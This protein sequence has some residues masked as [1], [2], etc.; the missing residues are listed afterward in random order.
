MGRSVATALALGALAGPAPSA[1]AAEHA[2]SNVQLRSQL[3]KMKHENREMRGELAEDAFLRKIDY[4]GTWGFPWAHYRLFFDFARAHDIRVVGVN[5]IPPRGDPDRLLKRDAFAAQVLAR[6]LREDPGA[7]VWVVFGDLHVAPA[8]L[9]RELERILRGEGREYRQVLVFQ[10]NKRLYF[11]LAEQGRLLDVDTVRLGPGRY[12]ILNTPP[13]IKLRSFLDHL[14][15]TVFPPEE[16]ED[17]DDIEPPGYEDYILQLVQDLADF[18][19]I[20]RDDLDDFQ[21]YTAENLRSLVAELH[22]PGPPGTLE[23]LL[24]SAKAHYLARDRVIYLSAF[25]SNHAAEAAAELLH[26]RCSGYRLE[27]RE[28]RDLFYLNAVAKTLGFFGSQVLNPKRKTN[29]FKDHDLF[30]SR[31]RGRRLQGA[32]AL[33]RRVSRL[34]VQHQ[35]AMEKVMRARQ[36]RPR[37]RKVYAEDPALGFG[38]SRA[39][40]SIMGDKLFRAM[41]EGLVGKGEIQALFHRPMERPGAAYG[42]EE[43]LQVQG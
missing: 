15:A 33:Q 43:A 4:A 9:P 6:C 8:H 41:M 16:D 20:Q 12:C 22:V 34:V 26:H 1:G 36:G 42:R 7:L 31:W 19:E 13:W 18:L 11:R 25:D 29:Y 38:V 39:L 2:E 5:H 24:E 21:L 37:L 30:L 28:P 23:R 17:E 14:E 35:R 3:L 40:G 10:N 32:R 27:E